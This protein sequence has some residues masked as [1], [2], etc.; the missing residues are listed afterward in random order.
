M[1]DVE[2]LDGG[3]MCC[4]KES[5]PNYTHGMSIHCKLGFRLAREGP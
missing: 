4:V 3:E 5:D 1:V 2:C